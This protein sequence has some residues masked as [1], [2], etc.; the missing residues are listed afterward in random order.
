MELTDRTAGAAAVVRAVELFERAGRPAAEH[1]RAVGQLVTR[2]Y[3][4]GTRTGTEAAELAR[5]AAIAEK[6]GHLDTVLQLTSTHGQTLLEDGWVEEALAVLGQ[7]QQRAVEG[8]SGAGH[9]AVATAVTDS[10]LW[11]LRLRDG[12]DAGRV[13]IARA[14]RD[15]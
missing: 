3:L 8:D 11:L 4:N 1:A 5:A 7:A 15:G 2:R 10:Y 13:G 9:L 14:L 6:G 12:L